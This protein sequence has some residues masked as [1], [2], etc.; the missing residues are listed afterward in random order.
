MQSRKVTHPG[1][2]RAR[3]L[4]GDLRSH[5]SDML[6]QPCLAPATS[7][8]WAR[9]W[10][11]APLDLRERRGWPGH[12]GREGRATEPLPRPGPAP[13]APPPALLTSDR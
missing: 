6:R 13:S 12:R 11:E 5:V 9:G 1:P 4:T 7:W 3:R 8:T 10:A 2:E